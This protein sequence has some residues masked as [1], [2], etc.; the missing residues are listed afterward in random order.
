MI[1]TS[2]KSN[3]R[4]IRIIK[5]NRLYF[6]KIKKFLKMEHKGNF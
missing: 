3:T 4:T 2:I 6:N 5:E 1:N